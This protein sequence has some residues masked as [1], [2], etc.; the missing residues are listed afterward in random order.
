MQ[1]RRLKECLLKSKTNVPQSNGS[2]IETYV[3]VAT[4]KVVFEELNNLISATQYGAN[5]D[6]VYRISSPKR[7]LER[8]LLPKMAISSDNITTYI[9]AIDSKNYKINSVRENYVE[10]ELI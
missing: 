3:D 7:K 8:Y 9:I 5:L 1:L 2:Y 6:K 4:Y 10:I